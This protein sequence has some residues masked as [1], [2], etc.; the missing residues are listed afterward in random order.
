MKTFH[1]LLGSLIRVI[2]FASLAAA[3]QPGNAPAPAESGASP[4]MNKLAKALAGDWRTEENMEPSEFFPKG[5]SRHGASHVK[6]GAGGTTL[7]AEIHSDGSAGKLDGFVAIWWDTSASIYRLFTCFNDPDSP[8]EVRGTAHWEGD[9]FVNDYEETID[10]KKLK[11]RDSF[12]QITPTS[13]T[14][15][16]AVDTGDGTMK[17]LITTRSTRR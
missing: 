3:Q 12:L 13:H 10:G 6:L 11:F 7:V 4:E 8:C 1:W 2:F 16:A 17:T 15:V 14:L 9:T 5:G